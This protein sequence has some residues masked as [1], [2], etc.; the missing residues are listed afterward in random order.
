MYFIFAI[1]RTFALKAEDPPI[2]MLYFVV[3]CSFIE[4]I[5]TYPELLGG[6]VYLTLFSDGDLVTLASADT[7]VYEVGSVIFV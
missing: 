7:M 3:V 1:S 5:P 4:K 6:Y 2:S